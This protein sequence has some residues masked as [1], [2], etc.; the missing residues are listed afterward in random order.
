MKK[1][2][3]IGCPGSG[4]S[5]LSK[6]IQKIL[7]CEILH[8]DF[9][10]HIDNEKQISKEELKTKITEFVA[11]KDSFIID[12]N[13]TSTLDLRLGYA[14]TVLFFH[15]DTETCVNNVLKR[16]SEDQRDDMA[17]GFDNSI[18]DDD[19]LDYIR[20]FNS[21]NIPVIE[22]LLAS[23]PHIKVIHLYNYDEVDKFLESL[24]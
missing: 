11:K 3:V 12:G 5:T 1:I 24:R 13:Y 8:L 18:M 6:K 9:I 16:L 23:Y 4:K 7:A 10:Y 22:K 19:F 2:L 17:P 21:N 15:I 20:D 14:D